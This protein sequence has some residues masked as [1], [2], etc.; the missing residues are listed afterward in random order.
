MLIEV[1][2]TMF[3]LVEADQDSDAGSEL[4]EA[5]HDQD[6]DT[7]FELVEA[8]QDS[9]AEVEADHDQDSDARSEDG[10]KKPWRCTVTFNWMAPAGQD[11]N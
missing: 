10:S 3:E 7:G 6:S 1:D 8:D 11:D 4:V 2:E 9:D 5:D